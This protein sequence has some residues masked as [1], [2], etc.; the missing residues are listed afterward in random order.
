V[1][2]V[3][4]IIADIKQLHGDMSNA[5]TLEE[6]QKLANRLGDKLALYDKEREKV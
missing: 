6:H 1:A 4:Y 3:D 2:L 5:K